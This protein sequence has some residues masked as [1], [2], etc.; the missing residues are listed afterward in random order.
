MPPTKHPVS[1]EISS[2]S[3]IQ[4]DIASRDFHLIPPLKKHLGRK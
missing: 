4:P 2:I 1:E 3:P